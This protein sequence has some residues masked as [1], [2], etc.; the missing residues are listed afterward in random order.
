M[1]TSNH[2]I[3]SLMIFVS[4]FIKAIRTIQASGNVASQ[5]FS[6]AVISGSTSVPNLQNTCG[7]DTCKSLSVYVKNPIK[8]DVEN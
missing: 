1:S 7:I 4:Q 5:L 3:N 8:Y 2:G 6:T